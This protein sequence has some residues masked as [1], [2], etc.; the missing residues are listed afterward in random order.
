MGRIINAESHLKD[1]LVENV[2][3]YIGF[4]L[5]TLT[6]EGKNHIDLN[7]LIS[8]KI[9]EFIVSGKKGPL[10]ENVKGKFVRKQPERKETIEKHI[11]Y[12]SHY[13]GKII[14]YDREF[15]V[16]EKELSH[17]FELK[18]YRHISPQ[19]EVIIHFPL[20]T[21]VSEENHF[22]RA[23][24]AM[25][26]SVIL[27]QY[28]QIYNEKFEPVVKITARLNKKILEQ[29]VGR[30]EDK[31]EE[32]KERIVNGDYN[33]TD[34]SGNSYR[35]AIL[36][37]YSFSDIFDGIGGFNEYLQFEFKDDNVIILENLR[38]G[39]ATYI[40]DYSKFDR[41]FVLDKQNAKSHPAYL[42][43]VVHTNVDE[44]ERSMV[45]YLK[46]KTN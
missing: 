42:D 41:K 43:R 10:R 20:F 16:W 5:N 24:S 8:G 23:K 26:I 27:G 37:D 7:D 22:L 29:G 6:D 46:K 2:K 11:E 31:I 34:G 32:I 3:Y 28:F 18:L 25:N 35:F 38:T 39:N 15:H 45:K 33:A 13:H 40:F 36:Q 12:Y 14:S 30:L 19:G 4:G 9:R 21:M 1:L 17:K 44:W